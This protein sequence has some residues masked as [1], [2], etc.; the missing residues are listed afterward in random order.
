[1]RAQKSTHL[2]PMI[3]KESIT[4][5][6]DGN[7][8][9][10]VT[11]DVHRRSGWSLRTAIGGDQMQLSGWLQRS[12][13]ADQD[14]MTQQTGLTLACKLPQESSSRADTWRG[15]N[16]H[17]TIKPLTTRFT[18]TT[19]AMASRRL[20]LNLSQGLRNRQALSS[21]TALRRGFASPA[22]VGKT[23]TTTLPNGLTVSLATTPIGPGIA[24]DTD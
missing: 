1:V 3:S 13:R 7:E 6:S 5:N 14:R 4:N 17:Q 15:K 10:E 21:T 23:Q 24:S 8:R 19:S 11:Y 22:N 9:C 2:T 12:H 18:S 16:F 20:A